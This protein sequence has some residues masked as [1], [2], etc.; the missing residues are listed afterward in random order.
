MVHDFNKKISKIEYNLL[1][2]LS[3]LQFSER[4]LAEYGYD[5]EGKKLSVTYTTSKTN[6]MV[7]MGSIVPPQATNVAMTLKTDY[8][9]N[10]IYE[11][12][13]LRKI[14]TDVGY[15][16]LNSGGEPPLYHYFLQDHLGNNRVVV[17]EDGKVEQVNHYYAFG[18]LMGES[19]G[20]EVQPYK[21][22]GKE[23]D[24]MHGLD[25]YDYGAR[26]YDPVIGRWTTVDPLA[27][28]YYSMSPYG[29]CLDDPVKNIDPYGDVVIPVH[30]TWSNTNTWK[31]LDG[32][33]SATDNLFQDRNLG[34]LFTWSGD[35]YAEM[36]TSAAAKLVNTIRM[37]LKRRG[38]DESI[39]LVG[40]SHG[41]NVSIEAIN[42]MMNMKEFD[43]VRINLLT[44]NTPVRGDY[45]LNNDALRRV[46]HVNVY[47]PKDPVQSHGGNSFIIL[48][49]NQSRIK[50]TGEYGTSGRI[51]KHAKNI[52]V[53]HPQGIIDRWE[54]ARNILC[55]I[56]ATFTILII[57]YKI[58]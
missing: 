5:A 10:M 18:G 52:R 7:P 16:T 27:E 24:R 58:G 30:G 51:F 39:T 2:L 31:D 29:Y 35:N 26:M 44:I 46:H 32:I 38:K 15:I 37:E 54:G 36:R 6:L 42:M 23:F 22:N 9:G 34:P 11:N 49:Q 47:D 33:L 4:H 25:W 55:P 45:Q 28:K 8:C 17:Q 57:G 20:D 13:K 56:L 14:L 48:P 50:G 21:Y 12:G 40:H 53:D 19:S 1:N 41:G 43:H 3:K